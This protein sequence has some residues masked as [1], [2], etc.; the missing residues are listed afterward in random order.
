L[1]EFLIRTEI[2]GFHKKRFYMQRFIP[3]KAASQPLGAAV[4]LGLLAR[5]S[6]EVIKEIEVG[7]PK[8]SLNKLLDF[9]ELGKP[10]ALE[11]HLKVS[12][13]TLQRAEK[14]LS[15][16]VSDNLYR[17]A[18]VAAKARDFFEDD[19]KA[20]T[21]LNTPNKALGGRTPFDYSQTS[22]GS[23][24]VLDLLGGLEHGVIQ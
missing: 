4:L 6:Q 19:D 12:T 7:F 8:S 20:R 22:I 23:Q 1:E 16:E 5:S 24:L 14:T 21:W 11:P 17:L 2:G 18:Q 10:T 15:P 9:L 3:P 13:K